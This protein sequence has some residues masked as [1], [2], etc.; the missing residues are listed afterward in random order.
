[1]DEYTKQYKI[2]YCQ[3]CMNRLHDLKETLFL[4]I[5]SNESYPNLE[6]IILDYNSTDGLGKWIKKNMM[7]YIKSGRLNY[8]RTEEPEYFSMSHSRNIAF[9]VATGEIV[10]NLDVDNYTFDITG[11]YK[12]EKCWAYRINEIAHQYKEKNIF[13][14]SKQRRHGRIGFYKKE[15]IEILGGYDE[16]LE[17]YGWDDHDLVDRAMMLGF[18]HI[19][20]TGHDYYQR[21]WTGGKEKNANMKRNYKETEKE[22]MEKSKRNISKGI[23]KANKERHW[24]KATLIKNFKEKIKI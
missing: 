23:F 3:T 9:K 6:F 15:F 13:V 2:S 5:K 12:P 14:K 20:W 18:T 24:G 19:S 4:N 1:M 17:G 22:N 7:G 10:N 8:Y 11:K 16:N 21:I